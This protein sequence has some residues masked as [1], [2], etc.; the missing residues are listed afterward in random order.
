M[1]KLFS[2]LEDLGFKNIKEMDLYENED[3]NDEEEQKDKNNINDYIYEKTYKCPVCMNEVKSK[4]VKVGKARLASKDTDLMPKYDNINPLFYDV[5]LCQACGYAALPRYFSKIKLPQAQLIKS[6]ITP[7]FKMKIYPDL[8]DEDIAIERYKLA[9][10]NAV[11]KNGRASEKAYICL[12]T[13]W[14]Y[15]LKEDK[16]NE[17]K[18]LNEALNGFKQAFEKESFPICGMDTYTLMYLLG[19]LSRRTDKNEDAL[20]WLGKV[21]VTPGVNPRLK[22]LARDQKDLIRELLGR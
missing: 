15:R 7:K 4:T 10:L 20:F 2:G 1:E 12:K 21:I 9:L 8:Y 17:N 5:V 18:F 16:E 3:T 22:E 13:A 19:E 6:T 14:M 11:I